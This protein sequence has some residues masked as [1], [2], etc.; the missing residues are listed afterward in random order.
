ME[1]KEPTLNVEHK[2]QMKEFGEKIDSCMK[3]V[4]YGIKSQDDK[5][6]TLNHVIFGNKETME[7]GMKEKVD[8]MHEILIAFRGIPKILGIIVLVGAALLT[9]KGW[10][11]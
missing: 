7:K 11:K 3:E 8:E 4:R 2:K 5:I 9:V 10:I 6:D 1:D